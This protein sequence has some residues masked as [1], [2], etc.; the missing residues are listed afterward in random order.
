MD[1]REKVTVQNCFYIGG[2]YRTL[3]ALSNVPG[4]LIAWLRPVNRASIG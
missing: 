4:R 2:S 1:W 3:L